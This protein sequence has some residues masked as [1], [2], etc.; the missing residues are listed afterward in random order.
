MSTLAVR[1]SPPTFAAT[2]IQ[3]TTSGISGIAGLKTRSI[4]VA[5]ITVQLL[6]ASIGCSSASAPAPAP[7]AQPSPVRE[8]KVAPAAATEPGNWETTEKT[9]P[10][11]NTKEIVL[12]AGSTGARGSLIIRFKGK[13][14]DVYVNTEDIV[15]DESASVRIKFDD[16]KPVKQTWSRSTDYRA[17]FSPDPFGLITRLQ[18]SKRFYIE[19]QPY[20]KVADTIIFNVAGL[21]PHLPQAEMALQRKK[22]DDNIAANAALRARILPHV[23]PCADKSYDGTVRNPGK[24]C[25]T[26]PDDPL[27]KNETTPRNTK[28]EALK[29]ALEQARL[30]MAFT[31]K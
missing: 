5:I 8:A 1:L 26:D 17:V 12:R 24:W 23:H 3:A 13:K 31:K 14:L 19:Y 21:A 4:G 15:D 7:S 27:F 2:R 30:G 29:D 10:M 25:W 9:D 20:Q 22:L 16:G 28:E 18:G 11:D 6:L